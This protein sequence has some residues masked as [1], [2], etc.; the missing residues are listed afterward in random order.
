MLRPRSFSLI[1]LEKSLRRIT[2]N[3]RFYCVN[4]WSLKGEWSGYLLADL[5]ELV[6][7]CPDARYL[8]STSLD[9]Y[10][11]TTRLEELVRGGAMLVTHMDGEPLSVQ[12][13]KPVRLMLF[14]L[15]QFKGVKRLGMLEMVRDYRPGTWAKV[16]YNDATIQPYPHL[17]IDTNEE[18]MPDEDLLKRIGLPDS[19]QAGGVST[20][21]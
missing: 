2:S 7:P 3:R 19:N 10:E 4:G 1:E 15:Y 5:I 6:G 20:D 14:D 11:D 18:L 21:L 8:R 13:G 17:S 9:G 16:G 12:R